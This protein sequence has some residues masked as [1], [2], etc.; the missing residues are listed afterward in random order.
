[1][2]GG[3]RCLDPV[4]KKLG[5][6]GCPLEFGQSSPGLQTPWRPSLHHGSPAAAAVS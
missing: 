3:E 2:D 4:S 5:T 6:A 1:M